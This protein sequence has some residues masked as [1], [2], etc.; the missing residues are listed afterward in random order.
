MARETSSKTRMRP[1][2]RISLFNELELNKDIIYAF[3]SIC[4]LW[5][6]CKPA[7]FANSQ[8]DVIKCNSNKKECDANCLSS[9]LIDAKT[10]F[11][12]VLQNSYV[13]V[14]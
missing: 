6:S 7:W 5:S 13:K 14:K 1:V 10:C 9:N 8:D 12:L 3:H 11:R 4:L 2:L